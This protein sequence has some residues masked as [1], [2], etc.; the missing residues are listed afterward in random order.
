M[1]RNICFISP[2]FSQHIGGMETHAYEF[3]KAF[4]SDYDFPMSSIFIKKVITD[5]IAVPCLEDQDGIN[6]EINGTDL[7]SS[8]IEKLVKP[9][10]TGDFIKDASILTEN[11]D[12]D[13][14][15]FYLNSPTWL[16]SVKLIK[17]AHPNTKIIVRSGG[18]DIIAGWI[19]DEDNMLSSLLESRRKIVDMINNYAD[20]LIVNSDFSYARTL[21]VGIFPDKMIKLIGG[22]DCSSFYP[23]KEKKIDEPVKILTT[24]RLVKFK[25]FEY[26]IAAINELV[27]KGVKNI[28]Y[29]I[30]GDGP[31]RTNL[32]SLISEYGLS[33]FIKLR[34]VKRI[35]EM[36]DI[37]RSA[38]IFLHMPVL[39]E[40]NERGSSYIHT[41]TMGRC[42]CEASASGIPVVASAV[43][44]M[45]EIIDNNITGILVGEKNF[46]EAASGLYELINDRNKRIQLG[47]NGRSKVERLF[48]WDII[49]KKYKEIFS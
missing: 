7:S 6:H 39:L 31:E 25:G 37:Y 11:C 3:A 21:E 2:K 38:D 23:S 9:V 16:P 33:E 17:D 1:K 46:K 10:L 49:F 26:S 20:V 5:G 40:K 28:S 30:V 19:G 48:D 18:N 32:V 14:T 43:G 45:P 36:P 12:L 41:E 42:L 24:A 4:I 8:K 15:I 34:G 22:V 44:G 47:N 29:D 27:K 35:D 13:K